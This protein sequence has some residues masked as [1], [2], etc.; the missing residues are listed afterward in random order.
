MSYLYF[1]RIL[2]GRHVGFAVAPYLIPI[3]VLTVVLGVGND[4][5]CWEKGAFL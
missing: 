3:F 4:A 1:I 2:V 5:L